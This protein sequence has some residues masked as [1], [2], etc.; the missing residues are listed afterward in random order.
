MNKYTHEIAQAKI[1]KWKEFLDD[2]DEKTIWQVQKY[3]ANTRT[4]EFVPTLN[5]QAVLN[6]QK[7]N[8]LHKASFSKPLKV[9]LFDIPAATYP[10]EVHSVKATSH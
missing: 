6:E 2:T 8:I 3:I 4:S 10:Q 5:E 9:D 1:N 7:V